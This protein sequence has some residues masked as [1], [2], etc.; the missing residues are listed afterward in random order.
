MKSRTSFNLNAG[1]LVLNFTNTVEERPGY[2]TSSPATPIELLDSPELFISWCE[3]SSAVHRESLSRLK[4][5]WRKNAREAEQG[6][7]RFLALREGLFAFFWSRIHRGTFRESD[8]EFINSELCK[9]PS[10]VLA[11]GAKSRLGLKWRDDGDP[12]ALLIATLVSDA[13]ELAVSDNLERIRVCAATDCGWLF[14]DTSKNGRRRWCDM[15][16]CGNREK[17]RRFQHGCAGV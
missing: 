8:I 9:L 1:R 17:Q 6:L 16:D 7:K 4:D 14:L 10:R 15:A 12:E 11:R 13:A 3:E 5:E 2:N